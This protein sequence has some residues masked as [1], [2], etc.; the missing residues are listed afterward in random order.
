MSLPFITLDNTYSPFLPV[1]LLF[2]SKDHDTFTS[3]VK[4]LFP[5]DK[6]VALCDANWGPQD[7]SQDPSQSQEFSLESLCSISGHIL[8]CNGGPIAW[9]FKYQSRTAQSSCKT[10]VRATNT[11]TKA[12]M[13]VC[14]VMQDL[15]LPDYKSPTPV[16]ND[17]KAS[18]D[19]RHTSSNKGMHH[20][21]MKENMIQ[22]CIH[23]G[24][25]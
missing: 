25:L 9:G 16:Y 15:Y 13:H 7:V 20:I 8:F 19:W 6:L 2:S 3:Y 17:S 24:D 1:A 18:V 5:E 10:E 22:D 23:E 21:D 4:I 12:L 14:Y 11:C